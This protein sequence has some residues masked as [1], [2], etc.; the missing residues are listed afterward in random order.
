MRYR[1]LVEM[2]YSENLRDEI[3]TLLA[4]VRSDGITEISTANLL[5]D[6]T[7]MGYA[8]NIDGL[9]M[10]LDDI[11]IVSTASKETISIS[12]SDTN[13]MVGDDAE[14]IE[15]DKVDSLATKNATKDIGKDL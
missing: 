9:L 5:K 2:N 11:E 14:E 1:E 15:A 4:M 10:I 12:T 7:G 13:M 3:I 8:I 6:L